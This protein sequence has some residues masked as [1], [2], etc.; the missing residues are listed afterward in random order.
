[1]YSAS[2]K[3]RKEIMDSTV[4]LREPA[5]QRDAI[6]GDRRQ[7]RRY[8]L[9]LELK[10]KLIRR[11]RVLDTG[12]GQTVDVSSGGILF[13]AGRHLPEG[14]NVELS[15][16]WPVLLHNVAPMQ[17]VAAGKIVRGD[18]RRVAIRTVQHEFRTV[19]IPNGHRNVLAGATHNPAMRTGAATFAAFGKH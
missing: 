10:W 17:L 5:A 16:A 11:R 8:H 7:D 18:G 14:L 2:A 3:I 19:G 9:Q 1:M 15:I 6:G 12:T 13:D 4:F